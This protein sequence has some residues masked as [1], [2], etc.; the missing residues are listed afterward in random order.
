[1]QAILCMQIPNSTQAFKDSNLYLQMTIFHT[2][3]LLVQKPRLLDSIWVY[4]RHLR[5]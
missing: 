1:M 3:V 2:N 5:S 4:L